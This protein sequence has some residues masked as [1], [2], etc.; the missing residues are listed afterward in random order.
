MVV[1]VTDA[2]PSAGI[3][4]VSAKLASPKRCVRKKGR[5]RCKTPRA[6][7]LSGARTAPDRF[8]IKTGRLKAGRYKLSVSARDAAGNVQFPAT[9]ISLSVR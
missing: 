4:G 2:A 7:T 3:A 1:A 5:K 6:K 8:T 9:V